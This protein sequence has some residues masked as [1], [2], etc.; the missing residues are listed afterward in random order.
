MRP[1]FIEFTPISGWF[2]Y[3]KRYFNATVRTQKESNVAN[4]FM[5]YHVVSGAFVAYT[6]VDFFIKLLFN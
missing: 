1:K 2:R 5:L 3:S 4:W 6:L